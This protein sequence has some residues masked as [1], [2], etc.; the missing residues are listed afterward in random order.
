VLLG[1]LQTRTVSA[2]SGSFGR[3]AD[4]AS[5]HNAAPITGVSMGSCNEGRNPA[6]FADWTATAITIWKIYL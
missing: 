6:P 5:R 2:P 3:T 4:L 1:I